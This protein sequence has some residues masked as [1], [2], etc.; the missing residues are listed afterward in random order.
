MNIK[1]INLQVNGM[2]CGSCANKITEGI[3]S[4]QD[5]ATIDINLETRNVLIS[6]D[7]SKTSASSLQ[8]KI[9]ES[10]FSIESISL[11]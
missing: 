9:I 10:G 1:N 8:N 7:A 6:Y 2:H 4:I 5:D 11:S 3:K